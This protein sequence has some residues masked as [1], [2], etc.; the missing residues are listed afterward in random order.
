M[1]A[2][3][4][5]LLLLLVLGCAPPQ[6][7][8]LGGVRSAEFA[9]RE[10]HTQLLEPQGQR[11]LHGAGPNLED[12]R[13][14]WDEVERTPPV[15]YATHFDLA[16]LPQDWAYLVEAAVSPRAQLVIPQIG[17]SLTYE[18]RP[19]ED[20]VSRGDMDAQIQVLCEG[21]RYLNR[22]AF[23]RIGYG[24]T[25][26]Y[27]RYRPEPYRQAWQRIVDTV[28]TRYRLHQ[29]AMVWGYA[30]DPGDPGFMDF[31]PGDELV[32]WWGIDLFDP[33]GF[34][35]TTTEAFLRGAS[36]HGHP[37][38]V[39]EAAPRGLG[40]HPDNGAWQRWFVPFFR[41]LR[42]HPQVKAFCYLHWT[43][44][45]TQISGDLDVL[46]EYSLELEVPVYVHAAPADELRWALE[47]ER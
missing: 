11:I 35:S 5:V 42:V 3:T 32:D 16:W 2:P 8:S 26:P 14:Y 31:Y 38:M 43:L 21:L 27:T 13:D 45:K 39:G 15:L 20:R 9:S 41:F 28:R 30:A 36:E 10:D 19:Y 12:F 29:V 23:L 34:T 1:P 46:R 47:W 44:G 22:P 40:V 7:G 6:D 24:V 33:A 17:L 4:L 25:S 18:G 37:V